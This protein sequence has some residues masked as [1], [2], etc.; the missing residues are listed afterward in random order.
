METSRRRPDPSKLATLPSQFTWF[1]L[2]RVVSLQVFG[3][4]PYRQTE[5]PRPP[6]GY[7]PTKVNGPQR[8]GRP[9]KPQREGRGRRLRGEAGAKQG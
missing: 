9:C 8:S 6:I 3:P 2:S 7:H 1:R 4:R 5:K